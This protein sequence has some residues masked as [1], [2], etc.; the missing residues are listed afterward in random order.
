MTALTASPVLSPAPRR[1][2]L[3][4]ASLSAALGAVLVTAAPADLLGLSS[5]TPLRV[6]GAVLL[7]LAADLALLARTRAARR[8]VLLAGVGSLAWE[9]AS[10]ALAVLGDLSAVGTALVVGQGLVF[11]ALGV[12]QLRAGRA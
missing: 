9:A 7:V 4:D 1:L 8:W 5:T 11:G 10:L 2:L 3:A 6:V 12:L